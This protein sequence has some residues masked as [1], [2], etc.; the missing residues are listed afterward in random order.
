MSDNNSP[1]ND[2][3]GLS[4][5]M[6]VGVLGLL[7]LILYSLFTGYFYFAEDILNWDERSTY[8]VGMSI[9]LI[10]YA[11]LF[12]RMM[13][14]GKK[15][16]SSSGEEEDSSSN[17]NDRLKPVSILGLSAVMVFL[18]GWIIFK[19]RDVWHLPGGLGLTL[20][21]SSCLFLVAADFLQF[22]LTGKKAYLMLIPLWIFVFI[23][24]LGKIFSGAKDIL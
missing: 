1:N 11:L 6:I 18:L 9:L 21:S 3:P 10:V 4:M 12:V 17:K 20:I 14:G 8:T 19:N 24:F 13:A 15:D 16:K 23:V 22:K 7:G 5:L 2:F